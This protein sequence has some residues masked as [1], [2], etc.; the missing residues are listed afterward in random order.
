MNLFEWIRPHY[1]YPSNFPF[2]LLDL[3][4]DNPAICKYID[5]PIQHITDNML[6]MMKRAHNRKDTESILYKIREKLPEAAIRTTL[7]VGHPG[8]TEDEYNS[9]RDFVQDFKF[10]RLGVFP[11]SNE[12]DTWSYNHYEDS[13]PQQVKDERVAEIMEIQ[14]GISTKLNEKRVGTVMKTII[15]RV[16]GEYFVGRTQFDSPEV[17]QEVLIDVAYNLSVGEFYDIRITDT[18]EFDLFGEPTL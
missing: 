1:L 10:D 3:M 7:I 15:D 12:E 17:D 11:Y 13:I 16:E 8:E 5:I 18:S 4:R 9:L 6:S 14:E 2:E